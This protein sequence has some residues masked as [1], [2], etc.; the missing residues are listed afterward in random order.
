M[1]GLEDWDDSVAY[2]TPDIYPWQRGQHGKFY[3]T[4]DNE[5]VHWQTDQMGEPHHD[6]VAAE[7]NHQQAAKGEVAPNGAWWFT[8]TYTP[9]DLDQLG[10]EIAPQAEDAGLRPM[11]RGYVAHAA[12]KSDICGI[13]NHP[14]D[15]CDCEGG[16]TWF[17]DPASD[18]VRDLKSPYAA[19]TVRAQSG[20]WSD[21]DGA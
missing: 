10:T 4:P 17:Q 8:D 7:W 1:D 3:V 21:K 9:K 2:A 11:M 18:P 5:F 20:P 6:Q 13:C 12:A 14:Y 19:H 16:G 15:E